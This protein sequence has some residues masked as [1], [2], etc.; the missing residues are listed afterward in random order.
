MLAVE[1]KIMVPAPGVNVWLV[2]VQDVRI[3]RVPPLVI[4]IALPAIVELT[5]VTLR[6]LVPPAGQLSEPDELRPTSREPYVRLFA[7]LSKV[8][9]PFILRL[10]LAAGSVLPLHFVASLKLPGPVK[11]LLAANAVAPQIKEDASTK[12]VAIVNFCI[13]IPPLRPCTT[14]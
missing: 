14:L 10:S 9:V 1:A 3:R 12:S 2:V 5:A 6:V 11:V 7:V 4:S 13:C 8:H